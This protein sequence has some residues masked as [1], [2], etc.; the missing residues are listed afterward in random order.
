MNDLRGNVYIYDTGG[1][2]VQE[3]QIGQVVSLP[4]T[5]P[6][7]VV[8]FLTSTGLQIK[9][10]PGI[11]TVYFSF[12]LLIVSTYASFISYSQ[13]WSAELVKTRDVTLVGNSNRAVLFFQSEFKRILSKV[14]F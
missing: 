12:F 9:A 4:N 11:R 2:L 10:D 3:C 14:R 13:I 1:K 5:A 8:D 7:M 6:I